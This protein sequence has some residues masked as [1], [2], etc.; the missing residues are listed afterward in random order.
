MNEAGFHVHKPIISARKSCFLLMWKASMLLNA[1]WDLRDELPRLGIGAHERRASAMC[2]AVAVVD[3]M[4]YH[5]ADRGINC[6]KLEGKQTCQ[7]GSNFYFSLQWEGQSRTMLGKEGDYS[8]VPCGSVLKHLRGNDQTPLLN[9]NED[10]QRNTLS[11]KK[12]HIEQKR[13][14]TFNYYFQ[15]ELKPCKRA[16][17]II[18]IF[19]RL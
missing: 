13:E 4:V 9:E 8:T 2:N 14:K 15:C 12:S 5:L 10:F 11:E 1:H 6:E 7:E 19:S 16:F 17:W 18:L 3:V